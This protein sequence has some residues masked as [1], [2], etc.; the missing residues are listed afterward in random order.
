M[1][2]LQ[3]EKGQESNQDF[4]LWINNICL[5]LAD[6]IKAPTTKNALRN[7]IVDKV[8]RCNSTKIE[9]YMINKD[10]FLSRIS[11]QFITN[12]PEQRISS[13]KL[14]KYCPSL[15]QNRLDVQHQILFLLTTGSKDQ[16]ERQIANA[17]IQQIASN[18]E[19]FAKSIMNKIEEAIISGKYGADTCQNFIQAISNVPGDSNCAMVFFDTI[20]KVMKSLETNT[21]LQRQ[22]IVPVLRALL[23]MT[24]KVPL[25]FDPTFEFIQSSI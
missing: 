6:L 13:L 19:G 10:E 1:I 4:M 5:K 15:L 20:Q 3:I 25:L 17:T 16:K 21:D 7:D 18:S 24:I 22:L 11:H 8:F 23:K 9:R 12:D 14:I 2:S